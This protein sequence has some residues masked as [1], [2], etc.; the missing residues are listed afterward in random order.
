MTQLV[1]C[2]ARSLA[3][4]VTWLYVGTH[5]IVVF[6]LFAFTLAFCRSWLKPGRDPSDS[7]AGQEDL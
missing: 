4:I 7:R 2:C 5:L 3:F 6:D 1:N